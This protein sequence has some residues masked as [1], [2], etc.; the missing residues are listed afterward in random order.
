MIQSVEGSTEL[1]F[2]GWNGREGG[3]EG[4]LLETQLEPSLIW[5][6]KGGGAIWRGPVTRDAEGMGS[7]VNSPCLVQYIREQKCCC[8]GDFTES[9]VIHNNK[10]QGLTKLLP[11][12]RGGKWLPWGH[13][14]LH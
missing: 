9:G 3:R 1:A 13:I 5:S 14:T 2:R 7:T 4:G 8:Y 11:L 6:K 12:L 10:T